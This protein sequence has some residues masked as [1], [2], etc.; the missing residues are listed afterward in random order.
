MIARPPANVLR[1]PCNR[2]SRAA[3]TNPHRKIGMIVNAASSTTQQ[4]KVGG[5]ILPQMSDV[6]QE[7]VNRDDTRTEGPRRDPEA[8]RHSTRRRADRPALALS[9][10]APRG[11]RSAQPDADPQLREH[12]PE[13]LRRQPAGAAVRRAAFAAFGPGDWSGLTGDSPEDRPAASAHDPGG[14]AWGAGRVPPS[15]PRRTQP[16]RCGGLPAHGRPE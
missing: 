6:V 2:P 12:G 3:A 8:V 9:P 15:G 14:A 11:Q 7:L 16:P 10:D 1:S 13:A 5:L 4:P